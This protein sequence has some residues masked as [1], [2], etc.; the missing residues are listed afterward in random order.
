MTLMEILTIIH[1]FAFFDAS[2][3]PPISPAT[4]RL[5]TCAAYTIAGMPKGLQQKIVANI[6]PAKWLGID[7]APLGKFEFSLTGIPHFG[8]ITA[9]SA[10]GAPQFVQNIVLWLPA[11]LLVF[12]LKE[13]RLFPLCVFGTTMFLPQCGHWAV[14][15]QYDS[16][17][18]IGCLHCGQ[19]NENSAI[20]FLFAH[21]FNP[22]TRG[23]IWQV[24]WFIG[25]ATRQSNK[26]KTSLRVSREAV[27]IALNETRREETR[28]R[29]PARCR[30]SRNFLHFSGRLL[31]SIANWFK[32]SG[33]DWGV[34]DTRRLHDSHQFPNY[35]ISG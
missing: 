22:S 9:C 5:F 25:S 35:V 10:I 19:R 7:I 21:S 8:H 4:M 12:T 32:R 16:S 20:F 13:A 30:H 26:K 15:P 2:I 14:W 31:C 11:P 24:A 23:A 27:G 18:S 1:I 17:A 6:D 34:C 3:A 33:V 28:M 29:S